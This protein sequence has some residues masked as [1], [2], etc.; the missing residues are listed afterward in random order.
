MSRASR[1]RS[2][3]GHGE[4]ETEEP[5]GAAVR[6][7]RPARGGA[8]RDR[9]LGQEGARATRRCGRCR[10]SPCTSPSPSSATCRRR[11]SGDWRTI[12]EATRGAGAARS[13]LGDPVAKPSRRPAAAL[14]PARP[15][16]RAPSTLQ[17]ELEERLVAA[18]L[19]EPE[20][21]PFWPHVTVARVRPRVAD[22]SGRDRSQKPPGSLPKD[23]L[24]RTFVRP[25]RRSTVPNSSRRVRDT[26]RWRKSS[27]PKTGGSEVKEMADKKATLK[28]ASAKDAKAKDAALEAAV[29]QIERDFGQ[30]SLMR[31]GADSARSRSRRSRPA[32]LRSTWRS[33][34]AAC[35]AGGS[36]RS[37]ARS[38][39]ERRR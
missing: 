7:A 25:D 34:S 38:P 11:R 18:R 30:G 39:R 36:S 27:C 14:R 9:G 1:P 32:P 20:K 13:Q 17:A 26:S 24:Q 21:R 22:R 4:G 31:L 35:R 33:A 5:A 28:D 2:V 10:A 37:S 6:G 23:L 15:I 8:G 12:V 19:Y 3:A 29:T 16:P